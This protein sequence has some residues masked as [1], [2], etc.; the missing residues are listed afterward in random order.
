MLTDYRCFFCLMRNC[1][2]LIEKES[3][4]QEAKNNFVNDLLNLY[5]NDREKLIAPELS[6]RIHNLLKKYTGNKDSYRDIK[7]SGNDLAMSLIPHLRELIDN[8]GDPFGTAVRLAIA[9]NIMDFAVSDSFDIDATIQ[10]SLTSDLAIDHLQKLRTEIKKAGTILYLGDNAGEIVFDR[11]FIETS[12][13]RNIT[14]AVRGF[15]VINDATLEDALYTG[16]DK[17][18]AVISNEYDAPSTII[19]KSGE[20]FRESFRNAD[21]I[22]SKGQGNLEGLM[23]LN[24]KRIFFLLMVKCD[25]MADYLKV[26][27]GSMVVCNPV[28]SC[29]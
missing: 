29:T 11:L 22:I 6:R 18:A 21:L 20:R 12:G 14:Y 19:D 3:L 28:L 16:M 27:K 13:Y 8:S 23:H 24:D 2:R 9:G 7:K 5:H 1:E 17:V 25:A 15:P 10:E 4:T 26:K